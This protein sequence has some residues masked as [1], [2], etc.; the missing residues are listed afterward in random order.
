MDRS[1]GPQRLRLFVACRLPGE[2]V[3]QVAAWQGQVIHAR[4]GVR[5]MPRE[6]LHVTLVFLGS[7]PAAALAD[8]TETVR[9]RT[10]AARRPSFQLWRYRETPRVGML[11]LTE[12]ALPG[13]HYA[14]RANEL[15][16]GLMLDFQAAGIYEPEKRDWKPHITVARFRTPPRLT[17]ALPS[18]GPFSPLDVALYE[19]KLSP[20]GSTYRVIDSALF[21]S[22]L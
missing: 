18:L 5:P 8:I 15:A 17:P 2:I 22:G 21:G 19:S 9:R 13:D 1:E 10:A 3:E 11:S 16:G 20:N 6:S 7:Q 4:G 14:G 12:L